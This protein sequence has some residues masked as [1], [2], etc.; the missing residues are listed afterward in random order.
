MSGY[1]G[2][3]VTRQVEMDKS[4]LNLQKPFRA[5]ELLGTV[6]KALGGAESPDSGGRRVA[7]SLYPI[8]GLQANTMTR[9]LI[10]VGA[11]ALM[12]GLMTPSESWGQAHRRRSVE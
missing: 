9:T 7:D 3:E 4:A 12:C 11:A 8:R 10:S 1:A 5:A 6:E 2:V